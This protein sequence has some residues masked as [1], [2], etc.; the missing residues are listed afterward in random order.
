MEGGILSG[1]NKM[2]S[3]LCLSRYKLKLKLF[4][5]LNQWVALCS[6]RQSSNVFISQGCLSLFLMIRPIS[7]IIFYWSWGSEDGYHCFLRFL[8]TYNMCPGLDKHSNLIQF[9]SVNSY[10][11]LAVCWGLVGREGGTFNIF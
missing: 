5:E 1:R 10:S 4:N 6:S 2:N 9:R 3:I 8:G 7:E 11:V